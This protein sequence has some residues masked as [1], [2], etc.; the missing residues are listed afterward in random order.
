MRSGDAPCVL[1]RGGAGHG[2]SS[3][4]QIDGH[5]CEKNDVKHADPAEQV[6]VTVGESRRGFLEKAANALPS[7]MH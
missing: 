6:G 5:S 4:G 7:L 1:V 3:I 2:I